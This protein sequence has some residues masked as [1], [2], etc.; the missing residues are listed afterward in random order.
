MKRTALSVVGG[1][2]QGR[3]NG[4][5]RK[6]ASNLTKEQRKSAA[7]ELRAVAMKYP[8]AAN[9]GATLSRLA[10]LAERGVI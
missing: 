5:C 7:Q 4:P 10:E 3:G 8:N 2:D 1:T 6:R 9:L